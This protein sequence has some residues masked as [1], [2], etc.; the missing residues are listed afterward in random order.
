[1]DWSTFFNRIEP[2]DNLES[3]LP[4]DVELYLRRSMAEEV[5]GSGR[6]PHLSNA[7]DDPSEIP[8]PGDHDFN[9][10]PEFTQFPTIILFE[11][12]TPGFGYDPMVRVG[13]IR[14]VQFSFLC[15]GTLSIF[16]VARGDCWVAIVYLLR[17]CSL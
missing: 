9:E 2:H 4:E 8:D 1:M 15:H 16:L 10:E 6:W 14:C 7:A 17:R 13:M 3:Y 11:G 12:L 5:D